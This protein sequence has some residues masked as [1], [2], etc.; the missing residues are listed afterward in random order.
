MSITENKS[1]NSS[2]FDAENAV[3][4]RY[5]DAAQAQ[6]PTLCCPVEYKQKYLK[7]IP[8]EIIDRDYGCGD[9]SVFVKPGE[10]VLDLGSGGGKICYIASQ[11]VGKKGRVI[12]VDCNS[13]MLALARKYQPEVAEKIGYSNVEFV[14][15]RIQDL[16]LNLED[17]AKELEA[18]PVKDV[19]G[20]LELRSLE[21]RLREEQ[22]MIPDES[23]DCV[24]SN[25]VLNLVRP[26]DRQALFAELH[27]VLKPGGRAVIS[28]IV[29]DEASPEEMQRDAT[30][31]SGCISGAW[32]ED[33]FVEEFEAAGFYGM[34]IVKR[35]EEPWQV[36]QGIEFRS[37]TI[38]AY[39][40]KPE[41]CLDCDQAVVYRGPFLFI[42]DDEDH[43][44]RRGERV[45]VCEATFRKLQQAPYKD[46]FYFIEPYN[47]VSLNEA[48]PFGCDGMQLRHP[49]TTKG[50]GYSK[51]DSA[52][53][54]CCGS[55]GS[56]C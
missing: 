16:Q 13:E 48:E 43:T 7:V 9:P 22:R 50:Q 28:D 23:I 47:E 26:E 33:L 38:V 4:T 8:Q 42:Q 31:W 5:A 35:Q 14:C 6:E 41:A 24:V 12:G 20:L 40:G 17:L 56:C 21:T 27:R 18:S 36:V 19:D 45:A 29:S 51:T 11:V 3:R 52:D 55:D 37:M 54:G 15:G 32:R 34:E 25:C 53:E 44:Y 30:L 2:A 10:T 46:S 49:Q 39:K 1:D